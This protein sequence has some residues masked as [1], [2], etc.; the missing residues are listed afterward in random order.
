[1]NTTSRGIHVRSNVRAARGK[2]DIINSIYSYRDFLI[3][4]LDAQPECYADAACVSSM[5][6]ATTAACINQGEVRP[7]TCQSWD[8]STR[9]NWIAPK[10]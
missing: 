9:Y 6:D 8:R 2:S 1:M 7:R 5:I 4:H 3:S 10:S